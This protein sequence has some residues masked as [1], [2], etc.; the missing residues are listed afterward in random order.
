MDESLSFR[1]MPTST[2]AG[3]VVGATLQQY[4]KAP[5]RSGP[6]RFGAQIDGDDK[7]TLDKSTGTC[8]TRRRHGEV[9]YIQDMQSQAG[10]HHGHPQKHARP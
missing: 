5:Q 2:A 6:T 3:S 1:R 9:S 7:Q 4:E 10:H 8:C